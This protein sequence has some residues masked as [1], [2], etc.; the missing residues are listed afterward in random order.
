MMFAGV[1]PRVQ[2]R[3]QR[4]F[5]RDSAGVLEALDVHTGDA[6]KLTEFNNVHRD[7]CKSVLRNQ[8]NLLAKYFT[9]NEGIK[10]LR[11]CIR[12]NS[13]ST[14]VAPTRFG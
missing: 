2:V 8:I 6:F 1:F 3:F 4:A 14:D 13:P 9:H 7:S 12:R 11:C 10:P 5:E